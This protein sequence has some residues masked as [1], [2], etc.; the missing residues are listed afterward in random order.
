[1]KQ[2]FIIPVIVASLFLVGCATAV[3]SGT[4]TGDRD[5]PTV[6]ADSRIT[7]EVRHAIYRDPLLGD[8]RIHVATAQGVV[9]LRGSVDNRL[10]VNRALEIARSVDGVRGVNIELKLKGTP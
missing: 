8:E 7:R 6:T 2:L 1:M 4:A 5:Y 10:H 9:T 3:M